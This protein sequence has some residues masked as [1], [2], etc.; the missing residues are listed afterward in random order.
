MSTLKSGMKI[1]SI[2]LFLLISVYQTQ[3]Q[4]PISWKVLADIEI[5]YTF[6]E[7]E[8][9]WKSKATFGDQVKALEGKEI[10]LKGYL[11]PV[12][13]EGGMLV[14]SEFPFS[15]CFFCGGAGPE[16]VVELR[17]KK[18]KLKYKPDEFAT[19]KGIFRLNT[20]EFALSYMLENAERID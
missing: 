17:Y 14:L 7:A 18:S 1:F 9:I 20:D 3:A 13:I 4:T 15:S 11:L 10:V 2:I 8:N 5:A 16:S 19:I 6:A 12:D